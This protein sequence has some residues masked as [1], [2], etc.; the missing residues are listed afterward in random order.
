[1]HPA[2]SPLLLL[3]RFLHPPIK[4]ETSPQKPARPFRKAHHVAVARY[5]AALCQVV[6]PR[7]GAVSPWNTQAGVR[8]R[9]LFTCGIERAVNR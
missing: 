7:L 4:V 5:D 3:Q 2:P 8:Y 6:K 1:M 9:L